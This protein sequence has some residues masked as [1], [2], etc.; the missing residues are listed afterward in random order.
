VTSLTPGDVVDRYRVEELIGAGAMGE[1][2]RAADPGLGRKV[3]VKILAED[4]RDNGELRARFVREAR[5][6]AA[7]THPNVVQVFLTGEH[8]GL[9]FLAMEFL[10]GRDLGGLVRTDGP[11]S[12]LEAARAVRDAS[13]GLAAAAAAGLVH[14]DVKPSNLMRL[15]G[16]GVVKVADF[17]LA[18]PA[19]PSDDPGLTA[20]GIVV[21]T[22]D[23][24]APEQARGEPI[25]ARVDLYALGCSLYFLLT[26]T[27]PFRKGNES[28]DKYL[29]VVAR[30]LRDPAPDPRDAVPTVDD[31]LAE[32]CLA[33]MRKAPADRPSHDEVA[34]R[35]TAIAARL[36]GR[37]ATAPVVGRAP[38]APVRRIPTARPVPVE[39]RSEAEIAAVKR[40]LRDA[41]RREPPEISG[42]SVAALLA[43]QPFP[44][45]VFVLTVVCGALLAAG[46]TAKRWIARPLV[47]ETEAL[48]LAAAAPVL[49]PPAGMMI[50][51]DSRGRPL[52]FVARHAVTH[53][54]L[55]RRLPDHKYKPDDA[56][57]PAVH[58]SWDDASRYAAAEQGRLLRSEEW[59]LA[60]DTPGFVPPGM[61]L[62]EWIADSP[63]ATRAVRADA[64]GKTSPKA[65]AM[66]TFRV[67][68]DL[69]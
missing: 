54:D 44:R 14:R 60:L 41:R 22:P 6:V 51:A 43:E 33:L 68:R 10:A 56:D 21:G 61:K 17:G 48:A 59:A 31:E 8:R 26:G 42:S 13:Q 38:T 66:T 1:V 5:A 64:A 52:F 53:R 50:V 37:A 28:E 29:K 62:A 45:T 7:V 55:A 36:G 46:V 19:A 63:G 67:A 3:A 25:D 47:V 39:S 30:H 24:I 58:V 9:P 32:L 2:Y 16:T 23:Y 49:S 40:A 65:D 34:E 4:H 12:S 18:K 15:D 57:R 20:Q 11:L 69:E 35:A 27:P